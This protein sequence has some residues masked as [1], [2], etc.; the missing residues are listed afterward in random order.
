M[1]SRQHII[2][3]TRALLVGCKILSCWF[4]IW[5]RATRMAE[6]ITGSDAAVV[7]FENI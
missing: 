4:L 3:P 7:A 1:L 2:D 5:R 6:E